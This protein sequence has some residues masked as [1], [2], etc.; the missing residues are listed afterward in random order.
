MAKLPTRCIRG[1]FAIV[2]RSVIRVCAATG[3]TPAAAHP[4]AVAVAAAAV[5]VARTHTTNNTHTYTRHAQ[6]YV[7][8]LI[9]MVPVY[10]IGSFF[11]LLWRDAAIYFDTIRDWCVCVLVVAAARC[12]LSCA[13]AAFLPL[14]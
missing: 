4:A 6:R 9:F 14:K 3:H 13:A 10:A 7:I 2:K 8:R 12:C 1:A 5:A 11:S